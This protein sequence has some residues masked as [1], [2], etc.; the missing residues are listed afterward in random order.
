MKFRSVGMSTIT[1]GT[2][3]YE[4]FEPVIESVRKVARA[5]EDSAAM[6]RLREIIRELGEIA[7]GTRR[8]DW[9]S[10]LATTNR[11]P[12]V[13][14]ADCTLE[15]PD[16]DAPCQP[17]LARARPVMRLHAR[18]AVPARTRRRLRTWER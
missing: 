4:Q 15:P 12:P 11:T 10:R 2:G 14:L 1:F 17:G 16:P 8:T 3:W 5:F 6:R 7:A 18:Q 13:N 9:P